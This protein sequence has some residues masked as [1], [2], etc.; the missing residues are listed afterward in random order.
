MGAGEGRDLDR[1]EMEWWNGSDDGEGRRKETT[2]MRESSLSAPFVFAFPFSGNSE[3]ENPNRFL[4]ILL[5]SINK[6]KI[7]FPDFPAA[8]WILLSVVSDE[9]DSNT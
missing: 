1:V 2:E 7:L 9:S 5:I 6:N 3:R 8:C 4:F